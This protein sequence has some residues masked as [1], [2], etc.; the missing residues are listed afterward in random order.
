MR[1]YFILAIGMLLAMPFVCSQAVTIVE[2]FDSTTISY[3]PFPASAWKI[4][5]HYYK[6]PPNSY[7]GIVPNML[8]DSI[9]LQSPVYD[10]R[11]M[12]F[13]EMRFKHICKISPQDI[14][15][16]EYRIS[17]SVWR[18]IPAADYL[19]DA[20]NYGTQGF[21]AASYIEWQADD[22]LAIPLQSWWKEELFDL[23]NTVG[24]EVTEFRFIL[25]R[26]SVQ[27]TQI[28][29]G[30]LLEDI[31]IL[32][33][34]YEIKKPIVEFI[35]P[36]IKD[37]V[38]SVGPWNINAKVKTK[39]KAN[40]QT[41]WLV[42]TATNSQET[43]IDSL[44]MTMV[45]GDSLW[46]AAIPQ[47]IAGTE[48]VYFITGKDTNGNEKSDSSRYYIKMPQSF[49][50]MPISYIYFA[51]ADT[52]GTTTN[53]LAI[54][55][56]ANQPNSWSRTL[57][58]NSEL[59]RTVATN[60][61]L[62]IV[63][64]KIA[65]YNRSY[66]Y[67][68]VRTNLKIYM[69]ETNETNNTNVYI[70]PEINGATLVYSGGT[71]TQLYW[72]E[73]TL[74]QP[75]ILYPESNLMVYFED[76]SGITTTGTIYWAAHTVS[77]GNRCVYQYGTG[78]I[79]T[80]AALPLMRF[81]T[82]DFKI[83]TNSVALL[84]IDNPTAATVVAGVPNP[85]V[86]T[87]QN[88]GIVDLDS[89]MIYWTVNGKNLDS[90][91]WKGKLPWDFKQ[92]DTV[93]YFTV[94]ADVY[95]T[96]TVWISLPNGKTDS[97]SRDDTLSVIFYGCTQRL[98]GTQYI[99]EGR[100]FSSV[101]EIFELIEKCGVSNDL[102]LVLDS[103]LYEEN[104]DFTNINNNM[105][106]YKLRITSASGNPADVV[107]RPSY[108]VG[109]MLA[110]SD[111]FIIENITIDATK[112]TYAIQLTGSC[113]NIVVNNCI[114][115]ADTVGTV[116]GYAG[117]YKA[118][119]TGSLVNM[120]ITNNIIRGGYY[121]IYLYG[122][123][124]N[125]CQNIIIDSNIISD[126]YYYGTYFYYMNIN[127][128]SY[129]QVISR[130]SHEGTVWY[131]LYL[132]YARNGGNIIGNRIRSDNSNISSTI[133]ALRTYYIDS[134]LV[135]N[136]EIYI[137]SS[138]STTYGMYLYYPNAVDYIHNSVLLTGNG[139]STFRAAHIYVSTSSSYSATYRN[140]LFVADGGT[141]PYAI[142][143]SA[144]PETSFPLYNH[145]D[146]NNYYSSGSL[147][148]A[149]GAQENLAKWKSV[150][151]T[152]SNS[153]N[154][155]PQFI[156]EQIDLNVS[157]YAD[158]LCDYIP[159]VNTDINNINRQ[160]IT[161]VGCY[162]NVPVSNINGMMVKLL[163]LRNG[164]IAGQTDSL[165][166]VILNTGNTTITSFNMEWSI[167]DI[168]QVTGGSNF[169]TSLSRGEFDTIPIGVI[170]YGFG[171]MDVKVWLNSVN[172][173][174]DDLN[175][176]DTLQ[177]A[178]FICSNMLGGNVIIGDTRN[179]KTVN[180]ALDLALL[181]GVSSNVTMVLDSG[182]Y[183]D[184]W[185]FSNLT[186]LFINYT[187]TITSAS[188]NADDV[189]LYPSSGVGILLSNSDNI[190][191]KNITIDATEGTHGIYFADACTNVVIRDCK[192]LANYSATAATGGCAIYKPSSSGIAENISFINNTIDGGYSGFYFYAGT[193]TSAFGSNIIFDSNTVQNSYTYATYIYYTDFKSI[194]YNLIT[195]RSTGHGTSWYGLRLYYVR[196]GG[197]IIG[198]RIICNNQGI[199]STIYGVYIY[200]T[201][202]ALFANNEIYINSSAGTTYGLY[203]YYLNGVNFLH[204][205]VVLTG[206]GGGT[207]RAVQIYV[208]TAITYSAT[209][210]NN[211]FVA[212]GGTTPYAVY[213][214]AAPGATFAQY[215]HINYNNYYSSG[216]LCYAGSA[217]ADLAAWQSLVPS[218]SC[219]VNKLPVFVDI[220]NNLELMDYISL[221]CN[222]D[223]SVIN[224]IK[225]TARRTVTTMGCYEERLINVN[226]ALVEILGLRDGNVNGESDMVKIIFTNTGATPLN[227]VNLGYAINGIPQTAKEYFFDMP[228]A[229]LESDT[230]LLDTVTYTS[231]NF[232]VKIWINSLEEGLLTDESSLDDT[233]NLS[234][235]V[236]NEVF[237]GIIHISDTSIFTTVSKALEAIAVC[238]VGGDIILVLDSGVYEEN[239]N[240]SNLKDI[241]EN[242]I[243]TITSKSGKAED[244][245][246]L[247][248]YGPGITLDNADNLTISA[249]TVDAATSGSHGI[250]F[251]NACT[252]V[253]I[254][255]CKILANYS[256]TSAAG[257][258]G[259][260]KPSSTGIAENISFINNIIDGGYS[261]F[262][263]YAGTGTSAYGRN[264]I[265]DSNT[266]QN[267]YY[268]GAYIYYTDFKSISY[269]LVTP[270][271]T[272]QGTT[273]YGLR[274]YY[275]RNGGNIIG[276]RIICN[277]PGITS[278]IYGMYVY[279]TDYAL[280]ANNEIYINSSASTTYGLYSYYSNTVDYLHN[281]IV[282]TGSGGATFR[283]AYIHV[284]TTTPYSATYRNN[285]FVAN[286]GTTPY[287][288]YLS[289]APGATFA[290][291]NYINDNNYY[292][293]GNLGYAGSARAT[294]AVWKSIVPTDINSVNVQPSF[295]DSNS[296]KLTDY[297][298]LRCNSHPL[299][300]TDIDGN[301]RGLL[302]N[303]G[304]YNG[305][306]NI[307]G[308][309]ALIEILR[310]RENVINGDNDTFKVVIHNNGLNPLSSVN[311]E[312]AVNGTSQSVKNIVFTTPLTSG[313]YDTI[314]IGGLVY[315][316]DTTN[317]KIWLNS[318]NG[319]TLIDEIVEDDTLF[320]TVNTC[321]N[322]FSGI[323]NI[324]STE[325]YTSVTAAL[326]KAKLCA[327]T[328]NVTFVLANGT[329]TDNW[330]FTNIKDIIGNYT[331]TI[332]SASGNAD[333]VILRPSSGAAILMN[334]SNNITI[335]NITINASSGTHGI[336]FTNACTNIVVRDCKIFAPHSA[337]ASANGCAVYKPTSSGIVNNISFIS[338]TIDGGYAGF[339]FY[340]GTG[341]SA[342]GGNIIIDSNIVQN[343]Y[344]YAIYLYYA[345]LNSVSYN[346]VSSRSSG[347]TTTW[348]GFY[349]YYARNGGNII[350]NKVKSDNPGISGT[351]YGMR[352]Y[353]IDNALVANNEIYL[354]SS[355]STTYGMYLYYSKNVDYL[356]NTVLL[357]GTGG[358]T[359]RAAHIYVSTSATYSATYKNNIFVAN[360]GTTPYA[361]YLSAAPGATFAQYN[362]IDYN[363]YYSSGNLGYAG[364][365]RTTLALWK[366][367]VP[368]DI[369]S[370]NIL[371]IFSDP[372][373]DLR[374]FIY[375][376]LECNRISSVTKD[377]S[378]ANRETVT[379]MGCY[380]M[381]IYNVNAIIT[382]ILG[383][384]EGL[385]AGQTD[386]IQIVLLNSGY[387][388]LDS[389]NVE[390]SVNGNSQITGGTTFT[391]SL[392]QRE[393]DTITLGQITYS[394]GTLDI[395]VWINNLNGGLL[396][397][398]N[399]NDDTVTTSI[400]VC[401]ANMN[402]RFTID[403]ITGDFKSLEEAISSFSSCIG[404]NII[405]AMEPG[406]YT[407]NVDLR[408]VGSSNNYTITITS[409]T[410]NP[411]GVI[412]R[413]SSGVAVL[414]H[415]T[416]NIILE[417]ITIDATQGTF[418]IQLTGAC[419]NI[420]VNNCIILANP[421]VTGTGYAGIHKASGTGSLL[422]MQ[423]TNNTVR[424]GYH[425]IYL[426]GA[427]ADYCQNI[428][429]DSNIITDQYY[430]ATYFY[431]VNFSSVSYNQV[432]SRSSGQG[433]IWYGLWFYYA[434]NGGNIIG[435]RIKSDNTSISSTLY[436]MRAYYIDS[437][438]VANNEFYLNS[439]ASTTY[440]M[441]L[442]YPNSVSYV[443]NSVLLTGSGGS[444]FR[445]IQIYVSTS[446]TY[447][448]TYKNNIFVTNGG[449]TPY[450]V[451]LSAAPGATFAQYNHIDYN[452][453]YSSGNLGYAGGALSTLT[454]WKS[455]VPSDSNSVNILPDF[456]DITN[457]LEL[458]NYTGL[459]C[460]LMS[461]LTYNILGQPRTNITIMGAYGMGLEEKCDI[462]LTSISINSESISDLCVTD[463]VPVIAEV[464]NQ[465]IEI[466]DLSL[467]SIIFNV[468]ITGPDE[469]IPLDT[470]IILNN[471][472]LDILETKKI[473]LMDSL[474]IFYVGAYNITISIS[475]DKDT[476]SE[477]DTAN[478]IYY[479]TRIA[480]PWEEDFTY[481]IQADVFSSDGN[482][483]S[484]WKAVSKG[485]GVDSL[486]TPYSSNQMIVFEGSRGAM[487]YL[488]TK[489]I[490]LSRTRLPKLE[491]WYFH[492]TVEAEDY[493]DVR[494]TIDGAITYTPLLSLT[495]QSNAY[496]WT[497]YEVDLSPYT[498]GSCVSILF[499]SMV[500]SINADVVQYIDKVRIISQ[501]DLELSE[502]ILSEMKV[503]DFG[504][505]EL[506]IKRT[507]TTN[508]IIDFTK[509]P[510]N[511]IVDIAG[512][513]NYS[514]NYSL[515][516][517]IAGDTSDIISVV[518]NID[519]RPGT[520]TITAYLENPVDEYNVN[521]TI[522]K[523]IVINPELSV[524]IHPESTPANCLIGE[525][526]VYPTVTIYNTGNMDLSNID[527]I[528]Q[529]DTGETGDPLY[530]V[531]KGSYTDT[532]LAGD[533]IVYPFTESY[534]VPW[535]TNYYS[536]ITAY[537][538]CDSALTNTTS[539][540]PECV[541]MKDLYMV[542]IDNPSGEKDKVGEEIQVIASL[543][544]RS[545]YESF[546]DLNIT[547][548]VE[549]SQGVEMARFIEL[550]GV[551]GTL[552]TVNHTFTRSYTV[553]NDT[554]YYLTVYIDSYE[555]YPYNDTITIRRETTPKDVSITPLGAANIFTLGQNIPNPA[556]N[557]TRIDYSVPEAG[558]VMFH[559]HSISGQLLYSQTIDTKRGT[560]SIELN[561]STFA[562]GVYFYSMEYKG[563]RLVRQLIIK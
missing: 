340:A 245:I 345:N 477:N 64:S 403:S 449:T 516:D 407:S 313:Q 11:G 417:A 543:Y 444:I 227:S 112:G 561:T 48:V 385:V 382:K 99:G 237:N 212:N 3:K 87:V 536:R 465:G 505:N 213:L 85:I 191:I 103:G 272:G 317:I 357:T 442:Y 430:Y 173:N 420:V 264:I 219:S 557:S 450:A 314:L 261:G 398:E 137:N 27:G 292:S 390:W 144:A 469:F 171:M 60:T 296:L 26:G 116:S 318:L 518:T 377:I 412:L 123:S 151:I 42:Y 67:N 394:S 128:V 396:T 283:A 304:C 463:F 517:T 458:S 424:G 431:Y 499:E 143:L 363:N 217:Q 80:T 353:Y 231:G 558:E 491:F 470:T 451:Y 530:T 440:G 326:E 239:W 40:I 484:I 489:Q 282:L 310:L 471:G 22:S 324:G 76:N 83:D 140:N 131:G 537:L 542:N 259:I 50:N 535:K 57:Y 504:A 441:Y 301:N 247:S 246:L 546:A 125:Y 305:N 118:S 96:L 90:V 163:G 373:V 500:K 348:Y 502:I 207:F 170:N 117:I 95:D 528:F 550:T 208:S 203:S 249:I 503:C 183:T 276:N 306:I 257:S 206:S 406:I 308:N 152:D 548:L 51:P 68:H 529:I 319:G 204:N 82:G 413:P 452:N 457:N 519:Y 379:M 120:Q 181:C 115:F 433:T 110:N 545:D 39:T 490:Q 464:T 508:Q 462:E 30:W 186:D 338:N 81:G 483:S 481:G 21:N 154:E 122:A 395:K 139:G 387:T 102:V 104:W 184:N 256:A 389:V 341:T 215:N 290:Q 553:P 97:I 544:N 88:K 138:A 356:H 209:Y 556:T 124:A 133:Y 349:F 94:N 63:I 446:A 244:V 332:T 436:G 333:D 269:N 5:T 100:T 8:G 397:D 384:R 55:F 454:M 370:V 182:E 472:F 155:K 298:G 275:T 330:N 439:S 418:G 220:T 547:V 9:V 210:N 479:N 358:S 216:N 258:C 201:D 233:I 428:T 371:P 84:S 109:I 13:I 4:N 279:Y 196:N 79:T 513:V 559:V 331:L 315:S 134:A 393:S 266:V 311:I 59:E 194:S 164:T 271:S 141:T 126:Q 515:T 106:G 455:T 15:R 65:W 193:G 142:Y 70:D 178:N 323:I 376:G 288:I 222:R 560:N 435:N 419:T 34:L 157:N 478:S 179:F 372:A 28:S 86:V 66:N 16:I 92:Q 242:N 176:D 486:V 169:T 335:K 58:L 410:G 299:V 147:G 506:K 98:S 294:L 354:N 432:T 524:R 47:F 422:N 160:G 498:N 168:L 158:M 532:I 190:T 438:L 474:D 229:R 300:S 365:A 337:T 221:Y 399:P 342:F 351:L 205:S 421:T 248:P 236:C 25:K 511:M 309:A 361:V 380:E 192:I 255:D 74:S 492:D 253:V 563:Q 531:F 265:F 197:N 145:I 482:T 243:L 344:Y 302:T 334:N 180:E 31:E 251:F 468:S 525:L 232:D 241:M 6:S 434:R 54:V 284:L 189:V 510:T 368:T 359:F 476:I 33:A 346:Q 77:N 36:L 423:I 278:T 202:S 161:T 347:Q 533:S 280:V 523:T 562:A 339:Y 101:K 378:G 49:E 521:D 73:V 405:L 289:A 149:G 225:G 260:Y 295:V 367:I 381:S 291:Y 497:L 509:S 61:N 119:G 501:P 443:H 108:G 135:A 392:L 285:I 355:A 53:N 467:D 534:N 52:T 121:G 426:Y 409:T 167:N 541:D 293:S 360:G 374:L 195:P 287:A 400:Y 453:Y 416:K 522:R 461:N 262:Y 146:Y 277:N 153:I 549:N 7:R 429:V 252:N 540:T 172:G 427:S 507:T 18:T 35:S 12:T 473:Q 107:L 113:T 343:S 165:K 327:L 485:T 214:S 512:P 495:K 234:V 89:A 425:G 93:G 488:S 105:G 551:I 555:N 437:A 32:S 321:S 383:L 268:Y 520:Y 130:S 111:N 404:G 539:E 414:M 445:A 29:Y 552:S 267:S 527:V 17:N 456:A 480:L 514:F 23:S 411:S 322:A 226:G 45:S 303:M 487:S 286:G 475:N 388:T 364:S 177:I 38:Y 496:G 362:H 1:K 250:Y 554:A 75:F 254:R 156:N 366:S 328:G 230:I 91:R 185:D 320:L 41:P 447:S 199:T 281:S 448:A 150:V 198:N 44:L 78:S 273:W 20:S 460:P 329:Y 493:T 538:S 148:Y 270:R 223:S 274:F 69:Q 56:H 316:S 14:I 10:F 200:Y 459:I 336:H 466:F 352:T 526:L 224:D 350:G 188:G 71:T 37:T 24:G 494:I 240:I 307:N 401:P 175:K 72:N 369:N 415:N 211:I 391:T 408:N 235:F 174:S 297:T 43:I 238:G 312:W 166:L 386:N 127:S 114:I 218:D 263:F 136:N 46:E 129:N 19:G 325:I 159:L 162:E 187:L 132:Y 375:T 2:K 402:G 228:L 62:P